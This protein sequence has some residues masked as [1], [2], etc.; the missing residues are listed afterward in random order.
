MKIRHWAMTNG[1]GMH[2]VGE[3][4]AKAETAL[5]FDSAIV[6][7]QR[8]SEAW[9]EAIE[10]D[11]HVVHTHMPNPIQ[12][13]VT[14]KV[15]W[16]AH[17]T[18]DHVFQGSVEAGITASY[19]HADS[20]MLMQ[21]WLRNADARVTFWPRHQW[22]YQQMVDKGTT[23]HCVPLGIDTEFWANGVTRGKYEGTP[24]VF[25]AENPHYIK[26]PYDLYIAWPAIFKALDGA[27]LHSIYLPRD[28]HRWFFPL[29]NANGCSYGSHISPITFPHDEL[30]HVLKSIDYYVG[31]VRYGDF[32]HMGLQAA[33]A[34]AK[35]ISYAGNP[36]TDFW[37]TEGDQRTMAVELTAILKGDV[38]PRS[39]LPVPDLADTARA[40]L[41]IY[42]GLYDGPSRRISQLDVPVVQPQAH[43]G[44]K[45]HRSGNRLVRHLG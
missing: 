14:G 1:S 44:T 30:R 35:T 17:G 10:A 34:G 36:Y 28:M 20:L 21:Y 42:E 8:E 6:D 37:I 24:S 26:W 23:V 31:L 45:H 40:M 18:P 3:S 12:K 16:V 39:K 2:R 25:T 38:T 41:A 22:I 43:N 32:N 5:G 27:K 4:I 13:K 11:V 9:T 19:G 33:C 29:V 15:V 7:C